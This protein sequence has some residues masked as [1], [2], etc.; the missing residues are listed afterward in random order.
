MKKMFFL[1]TALFCTVFAGAQDIYY[2]KKGQI[3][4][5][6]K[7]PLENI[8]AHNNE[9]TS[10]I[11]KKKNELAFSLLIKSFKFEKALMEEH[12]NT[13]Y[14]ESDRYPKANF[15][16]KVKNPE[17][18]KW[19]TDGF[20]QITVEGTLTI[21]NVSHPVTTQATVII[22]DKNVSGTAK[23]NVRLADY[24][25]KIPSV[26]AKNIAEVVEITVDCQYTP[27]QNK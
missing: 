17:A 7:A 11:D 2:T 18:V 24:N 26:V 16:G 6:S 25:I 12:F 23:F 9:V 20:Y 5:Y 1:I 13:T 27:M 21:H 14:M 15:T 22:K 19:G 10:F 8:E 4:F 3:S